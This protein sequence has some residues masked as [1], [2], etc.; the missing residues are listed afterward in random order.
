MIFVSLIEEY[1]QIFT[2]AIILH[3]SIDNFRQLSCTCSMY[4]KNVVGN[5]QLSV[6][7]MEMYF[8]VYRCHRKGIL[9]I[10]Y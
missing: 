7:W 4:L 10:T 8:G 6:K 9:S 3:T 1:C 2:K 5:D